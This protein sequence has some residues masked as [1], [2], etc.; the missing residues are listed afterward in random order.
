MS[1]ENEDLPLRA[2][3]TIRNVFGKDHELKRDKR[4]AAS[5]GMTDFEGML[6]NRRPQDTFND[7]FDKDHLSVDFSNISA[8]ESRRPLS[9]VEE[10]YDAPQFPKPKI[11]PEIGSALKDMSSRINKKSNGVITET[12]EAIINLGNADE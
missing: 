1:I 9:L 2:E 11:T 7:P 3:K 8:V 4:T 12:P 10:L 5:I 6:S